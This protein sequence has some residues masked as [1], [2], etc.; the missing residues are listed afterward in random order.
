MDPVIKKRGAYILHKLRFMKRIV[1]LLFA[2]SVFTVNGQDKRV[3]KYYDS[4]WFPVA[5]EGAK[6]YSECFAVDTVFRMNS[7]YFPSNKKEGITY[8]AD[9]IKSLSRINLCTDYYENGNLKDSISYSRIGRRTFNYGF[10]ENGKLKDSTKYDASGKAISKYNFYPNGKLKD[11]THYG[12]KSG[13]FETFYF[14]EN[15]KKMAYSGLNFQNQKTL[16]IAYD[17]KGKI[18]PN[19]VY[20]KPAEYPD[21]LKEWSKYLARNL[22]RDLPMENGAPPGNY[23]IIVDFLIDENGNIIK[24]NALNDPGYGIK[25]EAIRVIRKS[26]AWEPAISEN[27]PIPFKHSQ[28]I[29]FNVTYEWQTRKQIVS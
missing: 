4:L 28:N 2:F 3:V 19:Y 27:K 6:Y 24:I 20:M 23:S 8:F 18:L 5:K 15:G 22:N 9:T 10:Y 26:K 21:G 11:S 29:I 14:S 7:F 13:E 1:L 12:D 16:N 17:K 25:E